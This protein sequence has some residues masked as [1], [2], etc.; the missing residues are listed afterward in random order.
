VADTKPAGVQT[1]TV[2][3]VL[4]PISIVPIWPNNPAGLFCVADGQ[5]QPPIVNA[6]R[7]F[8][9]SYGPLP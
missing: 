3:A 4:K 6:G 5:I 2:D 1:W 7:S 8:A 9:S